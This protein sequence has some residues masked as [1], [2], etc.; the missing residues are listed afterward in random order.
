MTLA[1]GI[2]QEQVLRVGTGKIRRYMLHDFFAG[3]YLRMITPL[4]RDGVPFEK[5]VDVHP[6]TRFRFG[7]AARGQGLFS[8]LFA[9]STH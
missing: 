7:T 8:F 5:F 1:L 2:A 3:V 6:Y 9:A 4:I